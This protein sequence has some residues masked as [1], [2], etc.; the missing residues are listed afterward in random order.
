MTAGQVIDQLHT[1]VLILGL[2]AAVLA[3]IT[4]WSLHRT[5]RLSARLDR[6]QRAA[7]EAARAAAMAA[8][9]GIDPDAVLAVMSAGLPPTLDNVYSL[10]RRRDSERTAATATE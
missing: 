10:M 5:R 1:L 7:E 4:Y 8:P 2:L 3:A 6:A 9:G